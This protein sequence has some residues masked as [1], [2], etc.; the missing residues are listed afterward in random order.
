[1]NVTTL[2]KSIYYILSSIFTSFFITRNVLVILPP[3]S[4]STIIYET[5]RPTRTD[6]VSITP[7]CSNMLFSSVA[8]F[9]LIG[10]VMP[11]A[12]PPPIQLIRVPHS[13]H[14]SLTKMP[15][16]H[17]ARYR[18][19]VLHTQSENIID[20]TLAG[21]KTITEYKAPMPFRLVQ[22]YYLYLVRLWTETSKDSR[23]DLARSKGKILRD[24]RRLES[25]LHNGGKKDSRLSDM[26]EVERQFLLESLRKFETSATESAGVEKMRTKDADNENTIDNNYKDSAPAVRTLTRLLNIKMNPAKP[27]RSI[28]FG[29]LMGLAVTGWVFSGDYLFTALFSG[30]CILGQLEYYRG[31]MQTGVSPARKISVGTCRLRGNKNACQFAK[32]PFLRS[33]R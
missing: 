15:R 21:D 30:L 19:Q 24:V 17:T 5:Q 14:T 10:F 32:P 33:C 29:V 11:F 23:V 7:I 8:L 26:E 27:R 13:L 31:V 9:L 16:Q 4:V 28:L 2:I 22:K 20:T 12:P 6:L 3:H 18:L 25:I 1:M